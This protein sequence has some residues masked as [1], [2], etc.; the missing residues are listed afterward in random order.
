MA[1]PG[2]GQTPPVPA[3]APDYNEDAAM[4]EAMRVS[5]I[6]EELRQ[7]T[8]RG[9]QASVVIYP[10]QA[11]G[12]P[13]TAVDPSGYVSRQG[14]NVRPDPVAVPSEPVP[15]TSAPVATEPAQAVPA[16]PVAVAEQDL[17]IQ[18]LSDLSEPCH[19]NIT[20]ASG[21]LFQDPVFY[22]VGRLSERQLKVQPTLL[23]SR[24]DWDVVRSPAVTHAGAFGEDHVVW[25]AQKM[26]Q[27]W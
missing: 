7:A 11:P 27:R 24:H 17:N 22:G 5:L 14:S 6:E 1:P 23:M 25:P 12:A 13:R 8:L 2:R 10:G 16:L 21:G 4:A 3:I 18:L 15:H 20:N 19:M 26:H 9:R